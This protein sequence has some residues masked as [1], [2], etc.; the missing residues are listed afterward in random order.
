MELPRCD[1]RPSFPADYALPFDGV[2]RDATTTRRSNMAKRVE[3]VL[4]DDLDGRE[5]HQ[6]VR[7]ELDGTAY[8]I[9]LH[10]DNAAALREAMVPYIDGSRRVV[11]SRRPKKRRSGT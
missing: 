10:D 8:D 1:D 3:T 2:H 7:F 5:A 4:V 6:T 11:A 9:D